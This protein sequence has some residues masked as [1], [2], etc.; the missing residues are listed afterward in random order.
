MWRPPSRANDH[1]APGNRR[2]QRRINVSASTVLQT[3]Q[4]GVMVQPSMGQ[5]F[6][7]DP[8]PECSPLVGENRVKSVKP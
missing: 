5:A 1:E 3:N 7:V 4:A 8:K 6:A 2:D